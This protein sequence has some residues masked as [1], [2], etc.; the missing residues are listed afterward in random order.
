MT[1]AAAFTTVS[2]VLI[3]GA[4]LA[5]RISIDADLELRQTQIEL[6]LFKEE[7]KQLEILHKTGAE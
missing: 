3:I 5:Y 7:T 4:L 2:I 1:W 6:E